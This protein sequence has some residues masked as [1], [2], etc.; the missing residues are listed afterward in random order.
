MRS[1][2]LGEAPIDLSASAS[3]MPTPFSKS[4]R[5]LLIARHD[6]QRHQVAYEQVATNLPIGFYT[7]RDGEI[8]DSNAM[9]DSMVTR[10]PGA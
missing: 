6:S 4:L 1:I 3:E 2:S 7:Y 10:L 9:W 8:E 5:E